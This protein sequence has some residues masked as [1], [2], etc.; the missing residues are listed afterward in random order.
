MQVS[1]DLRDYTEESLASKWF[2][3]GSV[4]YIY[5]YISRGLSSDFIR[6]ILRLYWENGKENGNY[7]CYRVPI[8][9]FFKGF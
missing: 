3:W 9:I 5:I 8:V 6:V 1:V 4:G 2:Y 7:Y